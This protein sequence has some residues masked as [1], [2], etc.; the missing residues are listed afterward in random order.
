MQVDKIIYRDTVKRFM[1]LLTIVCLCVLGFQ[2]NWFGV[3]DAYYGSKYFRP[4]AHLKQEMRDNQAV[5]L[6]DGRIFLPHSKQ[7]EIFDPKAKTSILVEGFQFLPQSPSLLSLKE[8]K[9]L[10]INGP[11]GGDQVVSCF[12]INSCPYKNKNTLLFDVKK[13]NYKWIPYELASV[14]GQST[15]ILED[16]KVLII[17]GVQ[18]RD[19]N[20]NISLPFYK[21]KKDIAIYDPKTYKTK[22]IG[23]LKIHRFDHEAVLLNDHEVLVIGGYKLVNP[24]AIQ[25]HERQIYEKSIEIVNLKTG[26]SEILVHESGRNALLLNN[27]KLL[28]PWSFIDYNQLQAKVIDLRTRRISTI[29]K[30]L[31]PSFDYE[32]FGDCF[33]LLNNHAICPATT[34]VREF[35]PIHLKMTVNFDKIIGKRLSGKRLFYTP[36]SGYFLVGHARYINESALMVQKF[37]YERYLKDLSK[38]TNNE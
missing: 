14:V 5:Q 17:G 10:F 27:N 24:K 21:F 37:D 38:E 16:G 32:G 19:E 36:E 34:Q 13:Y 23:K 28:I 3:Q 1:T 22:F 31:M 2:M 8:D 15:S 12:N 4:Y 33:L 26:T 29:N 18:V 20:G 25:T 9:V 6:N 7:S 11:S 35:D 30:K